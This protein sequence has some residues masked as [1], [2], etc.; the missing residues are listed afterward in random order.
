M[1]ERRQG[2]IEQSGFHHQYHKIALDPAHP[3]FVLTI[4]SNYVYLIGHGIVLLPNDVKAP[5]A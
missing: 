2:S 1:N 3:R 4:G 5:N